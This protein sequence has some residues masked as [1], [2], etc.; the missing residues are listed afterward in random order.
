MSYRDCITRLAQAA[1]RELSDVEVRNIYERVHKAALDIKAGRA[2]A[3]TGD[4]FDNIVQQ[5]AKLAADELIREAAIKQQQAHLQISKLSARLGEKETMIQSGVKPLDSVDREIFR[6]YDGKTDVASLEQ[7]ITGYKSYFNSKLAVVMEGLGRKWWGLKQDSEMTLNLVREMLGE[8]TGEPIAGNSGKAWKELTDEM[9][10]IMREK[11]GVI[12]KM[13]ESYLP[14]GWWSQEIVSRI[15]RDKYVEYMLPEMEKTRAKGKH[16]VDDLGQPWS[17]ERLTEV[18]GKAWDTIATNGHANTEPGQFRGGGGVA[19]RHAEHRQIHFADAESTLAAWKKFGGKTVPEI[20]FGHTAAMARD[21]ALMDWGGPN[22]Q[23]TYRTMRD[24]ALKAEVMADPTSTG[25]LEAK[26]NRMDGYFDY[27]TGKT[28]PI[29]HPRLHR[30]VSNILPINVM[31]KLG[32]A[33][34]ASLFGDKVMF[35]AVR[36]MNDLPMLQ[37]WRTETAMLNPLNGAE[38]RLL[39][40]QGLMLDE[41]R[42]GLARF[43]E[44]IGNAP[45][46][47]RG[48]NL[49]MQVTGMNLA[50]NGRKGALGASLFNAIGSEL[51]AGKNFADLHQSDRRILNNWGITETDWK[52]WQKAELQDIGHGNDKSLT[53]EAISRIEG[54][55]PVSKRDAIVKLLGA[56]NTESEFGVVTPGM[57]EHAQF[58]KLGNNRSAF[59]EIGKTVLQFKSFPWA[60]FQRMSDAVAQQPGGASKAAMTAYLVTASTLAGAMIIQ[61]R[62]TLSGKDP[63]DMTDWRFWVSAF[64]QGGSL[65][66]YGDFVYSVDS[67]RYGSGP[68]EVLSGPTVGP[69]LEMGLVQPLKAAKKAIEGK[70]THL[71]AQTLQDAKGFVPGNNIWFTKAALDHLIW[72]Q[73]MEALS[74]G[75]LSSIRSRTAKEHG[76]DWWWTP[77]EAAPDRAPNLGAAIGE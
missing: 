15:G 42:G 70:E 31:G 4:M 46:A 56:V 20:L 62:E 26:A 36:H 77:G 58:N 17:R 63:R 7:T 29:S 55:D 68:L 25:A 41:L 22:P 35:E 2:E 75:Y 14:Q 24:Q 59:G 67:T 39:M 23:L 27:A 65:G 38:R 66:L 48:A 69:L 61:T 50:N 37:T 18:L 43:G 73:S 13:D 30:F 21:I 51:Q 53:P 47:N 11:G 57:K 19:N 28:D 32:G 12:G 9:H 5:S 34:W 64:F 52:V 44:E 54:I 1:G 40:R 16:Y 71:M 33:A 74:P 60:Q 45:L 6:N 10:G 8:K 49:V 72:Q 3:K 76:Q